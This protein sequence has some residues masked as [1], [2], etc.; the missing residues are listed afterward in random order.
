MKKALSW[1][2][3]AFAIALLVFDACAAIGGT[4]TL[5]IEEREIVAAGGSG[6]DLLGSH[7]AEGLLRFFVIL[8]SAIGWILS[9]ISSRIAPNRTVERFSIVLIVL[10]VLVALAHFMIPFLMY[11]VL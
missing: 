8:V 1:I 11:A 7:I 6:V 4:V 10:F 9:V 3:F 5:M 2:V